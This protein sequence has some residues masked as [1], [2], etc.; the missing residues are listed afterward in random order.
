M[1]CPRPQKNPHGWVLEEADVQKITRDKLV[2]F[3]NAFYRPNKALLAIADDSIRRACRARYGPV[4][5]GG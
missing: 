3:R 2:T 1:P 4:V 5:S